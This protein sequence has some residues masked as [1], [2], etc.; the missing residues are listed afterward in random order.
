LN[1]GR[2]NEGRYDPSFE[3]SRSHEGSRGFENRGGAEGSR[4]F[5]GSGEGGRE[6]QGYTRRYAGSGRGDY[7]PGAFTQ[8]FGQGTEYFGT[9]QR[10]YGTTWGGTGFGGGS[11]GYTGGP[12]SYSG[13]MG[14]YGEQGR[15]AG[16]GPKGYQRSDERIREDVCERLTHHPE[17]DAGEI[18]IQ[19]KNGEVTLT[20]TVERREEKRMAED[21]AEAVSGV[22][23][24]HNQLRAQPHH[25][26]ATSGQ[27]TQSNP[28]S[29]TQSTQS[30][31]ETVT[32]KK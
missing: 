24:V 29:N 14:S 7:G 6:N 11:S 28:Q 15:H 30:N 4:G 5:E 13:G 8:Q 31:R 26:G 12:G 1:E 3:G 20:G 16:R 22:K 19:V 23:D 10:G 25:Q 32:Q 21:V 17:I 9:G 2:W 18:D 27:G